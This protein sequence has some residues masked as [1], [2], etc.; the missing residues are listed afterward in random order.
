M[1]KYLHTIEGSS[2]YQCSIVADPKYRDKK[3]WYVILGKKHTIHRTDRSFF[4]GLWDGESPYWVMGEYDLNETNARL[5]RLERCGL[6]LV[7]NTATRRKEIDNYLNYIFRI[8]RDTGELITFSALCELLNHNSVVNPIRTRD[9]HL[10][11]EYQDIYNYLHKHDRRDE[12]SK[13][14]V[15]KGE[16]GH[17]VTSLQ[18]PL[19]HFKFRRLGQ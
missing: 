13:Y 3:G 14:I 2:P 9:E 12:W 17:K 11:W 7:H 6:P 16:N 5:S 18:D 10:P 8:L 19:K 1:I 4:T 15:R